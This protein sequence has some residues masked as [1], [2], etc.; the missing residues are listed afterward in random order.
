MNDNHIE[1]SYLSFGKDRLYLKRRFR[2]F[3]IQ[4]VRGKKKRGETP[5]KEPLALQ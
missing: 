1:Q 3:L 5:N 2:V 4:L